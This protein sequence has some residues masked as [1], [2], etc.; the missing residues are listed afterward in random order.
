M[1]ERERKEDKEGRVEGKDEQ[2]YVF[3]GQTD[4]Y[5]IIFNTGENVGVVLEV[6]CTSNITE[7]HENY[8][9]LGCPGKLQV[10]FSI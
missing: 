8:L 4:T 10:G 5:T 1:K 3:I 9:R 7:D 6:L 2:P